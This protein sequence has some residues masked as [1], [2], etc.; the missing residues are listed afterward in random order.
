M[1]N[2]MGCVVTIQ[3]VYDGLVVQWN[4]R[5]QRVQKVQKI[6]KSRVLCIHGFDG[7]VG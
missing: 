5:V 7:V 6:Q 1:W 2:N 3:V 4:Q